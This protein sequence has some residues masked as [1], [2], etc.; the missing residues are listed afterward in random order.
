VYTGSYSRLGKAALWLLRRVP[1]KA[2][3]A[4]HAKVTRAA[5]RVHGAALL[6]VWAVE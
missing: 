5:R 3:G 1:L 6:V 2:D 4:A